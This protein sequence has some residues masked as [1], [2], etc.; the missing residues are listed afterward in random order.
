M[1]GGD[2]AAR[3]QPI[4]RP[5][6]MPD[7]M[8]MMFLRA[9]PYSTPTVGPRAGGGGGWGRGLDPL[10]GCTRMGGGLVGREGGW[11]GWGPGAGGEGDGGGEMQRGGG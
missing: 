6:L 10:Q 4:S 9:P 3:G 7:A 2:G 11:V 8:A 5:S 1:W